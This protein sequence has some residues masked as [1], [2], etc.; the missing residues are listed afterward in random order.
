M[1]YLG[2]E[3]FIRQDFLELVEYTIAQDMGVMI[4]TNGWF[5]DS[6][7]AHLLKKLGVFYVRVSIDG[8][9][10]KTHDAIRG[11]KGSYKKAITAI[12]NLKNANIP[13]VSI[14]PTVMKDNVHEMGELIDLAFN[15]QVSEIQLVQVADTGRADQKHLLT[16]KDVLTLKEIVNEKKNRYSP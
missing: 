9:T 12:E 10:E 16:V 2:G 14:A 4:N 6:N 7:M 15:L 3:S 5:I 13:F 8:A 1:Y 11:V